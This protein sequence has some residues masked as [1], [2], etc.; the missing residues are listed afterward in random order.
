MQ[1][2]QEHND[3]AAEEAVLAAE[4]DRE[5]GDMFRTRYRAMALIVAINTV[6]FSAIGWFLDGPMTADIYL[7]LSA[8]VAAAL[9]AAA[10]IG[11]VTDLARLHWFGVGL[12]V[13]V[14]VGSV[15]W[16][17]SAGDL[18]TLPVIVCAMTIGSAAL[19]PWSV[20]WQLLVVGGGITSW[21]INLA[22]VPGS[23]SYLLGHA[24]SL[25]ITAA[26]SIHVTATLGRQR[27]EVGRERQRLSRARRDLEQAN[28]RLEERVYERTA[29]L[30]TMNRDLETFSF[31][32]SH[33][34]RAPARTIHG[35]S[36]LLENE[37]GDE[38]SDE[39]RR[40][41][42]GMRAAA[43]RLDD[44][45][46]DLL[47]LV[48][49]ARASCLRRPVDIGATAREIFAEMHAATPDRAIEFEAPDDLRA[50]GDPGLLRIA[51]HN[52]IANACKYTAGRAPAVVRLGRRDTAWG[53]AFYVSDNG[54]G[55]AM[56]DAGRI[57][58][59]FTRLHARAAF[60]GTGLGL[61]TVHR[62]IER[63]GGKVWAEAAPDK[64]AT[65]YWTLPTH[66]PDTAA[67]H[68]SG[69]REERASEAART[70]HR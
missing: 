69:P 21:V 63:H 24:A 18:R 31:S 2:D 40:L 67:V 43:R 47:T 60:E 17:I 36:E 39:A 20:G 50:T 30:E 14:Y 55:F 57:F 23:T 68:R 19:L 45:I 4:L 65:I 32:V 10:G 12:S 5:A 26:V 54:V 46:N 38:L 8:Q 66:H 48:R 22:L 33:D 61:A 52:L 15:G 29:E 13:I 37:H 3:T 51:L 53:P 34:L 62:I 42:A 35:Y 59:P 25:L 70:S 58:E 64:G 49:V 44:L 1:A 28:R 9:A 11:R 27:Y 41:L 7:L 16:A 56:E 6:V